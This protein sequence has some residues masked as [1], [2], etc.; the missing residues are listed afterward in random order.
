MTI[1]RAAYRLVL[2]LMPAAFREAHGASAAAMAEARVAEETGVRTLWRAAHEVVDLLLAV[3]RIRREYASGRQPFGSTSRHGGTMRAA[4]L[5]DLRSAARSLSRSRGFLAVSLGTLAGGVGLCVMVM[6]VVNTYLVRG[7]PYPEADR[8]YS[9]RFTQPNGPLFQHLE[10]VD[11]TRVSDVVEHAVSWDLDGFNMRGAPYPEAAQGT[12]VTP[13]YMA[14]FGIQPARG[15]AFEPEDYAPNAPLVAIISHRIW[16]TRFSGDPGVVGR[17]FE[18]H[19]LDRPGEAQLFTVVGVLPQNHWHLNVFTDV[20]APL[21]AASYPYMV[22]LRD[23]VTPAQA[24]ERITAVVGASGVP[25]PEGWR[26]EIVST[27]DDYVRQVRPLLIAVSIA[28]GL[29]LLIACA[30]VAVLFT[31]RA[32]ERAREVAVRKA[33]G[34]SSGRVARGLASEAILLGAAATAL[35][36]V[37]ATL[38]LATTAPILERALGRSAPGGATAFAIDATALAGGLLAGLVVTAICCLAQLWASARAPLAATLTSGQKGASAGPQQRRAHASLIALE[39]AVCLTLLVGATLMIQ[40]GLRILRVDMGLDTTD[41]LVGRI[42]L[43]PRAYPDAAS[44][45]AFYDR[46]AAEASAV[47]ALRGLA[48]TSSW[49]LQQAQS[50]DVGPDAADRKLPARAGLVVVSEAYFN[51]LSIGLVDGRGFTAADRTGAERVTVVSRTLA[52]RLWPGKRAVGERLLIGN[53]LAAPPNTPPTSVLVVGVVG[54]IRHAHTDEDLADAYVPM[55]QNA[56]PGAFVYI[57]APGDQSVVERE[58]RGL[59]A[60]VDPDM[61]LGVPRPLGDILDQQRAGSR[62]LASLLVVFSSFAAL[63]ALIGIYGAIAYTVRQREREIAVRL[64]VGADG[65]VITRLFLRQGGLVLSVGLLAGVAGAIL[66][67]RVLQTQ[68]FGVQ[69]FDPVIIAAVAVAFG[70]CGLAAVALPARAAARTD[71]AI[72]LKG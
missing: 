4:W 44:R 25:L 18:A 8:L 30:N 26:T 35:G 37:L 7:L 64:A 17:R 36:L 48:F 70:L 31:V 34:A 55:L 27:H 24:L 71:P 15:R 29:V 23:G 69:A 41:V 13:G 52:S 53:T 51:T 62:F 45:V 59:L 43:N 47:P 56:V 46:V 72:A 68:L 38:T 22:R 10:K 67:G 50:R 49:P 16:L 3:P 65:A 11:W 32:T 2:G 39:V 60:R 40:S 28:T 12:W 57:R 66:L 20:L 9:L 21:R 6:V 54:D 33:L 14:A 58:L 5:S 61:G 63:L 19:V 42:S 1:F